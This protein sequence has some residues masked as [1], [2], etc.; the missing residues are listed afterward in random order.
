MIIK[1]YTNGWNYLDVGEYV[2]TYNLRSDK[3]NKEIKDFDL[4]TEQY[5]DKFYVK[6]MNRIFE[7]SNS[8]KYQKNTMMPNIVLTDEFYRYCNESRE[9]MQFVR[10][11]MYY[12]SLG[13][14]CCLVYYGASYLLNDKGVTLEVLS[15]DRQI[16]KQTQ[17]KL[18]EN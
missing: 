4:T 16:D 2:Q 10:V 12:D 17:S 13:D 9:D 15:R 6:M 1:Y 8:T 11:A 3:I 18:I 5:R 14:Y 7:E